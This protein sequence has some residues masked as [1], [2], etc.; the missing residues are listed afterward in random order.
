M[1]LRGLEK[2]IQVSCVYYLMCITYCD[3]S[4]KTGWPIGVTIHL[5][6]EYI[7]CMKSQLSILHPFIQTWFSD[8]KLMFEYHWIK[9]WGNYRNKPHFHHSI[10]LY[11]LLWVVTLKDS[12]GMRD[13]ARTCMQ[14]LTLETEK[15]VSL[16]SRR[17][18]ELW[19]HIYVPNTL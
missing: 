14:A 1:C 5:L 13:S 16:S 9:W 19:Q 2:P 6:H 12:P 7:K 3:T 17:V 18:V 15:S 4:I 8:V 10:T 11:Y